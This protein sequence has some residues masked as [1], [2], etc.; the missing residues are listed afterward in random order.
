MPDG[1]VIEG[2]PEGFS[3]ADLLA[4]YQPK[5]APT[6]RQQTLASIP[7]R[8]LKGMKDPLDAGAQLLTHILPDS[9]VDAGNSLNNWLADKTGVVSRL[10]E[11]NLSSLVTGQK[12]GL[13]QALSDQEKE[14]QGARAATG[15]TGVDWARLGGNVASPVNLILAARVPQAATALGR[16]GT[17]AAT[18]G[19]F[20][21]L[22]PV[23]EGN[24]A[25]E[26]AKQIGL[27]AALGPVAQVGGEALARVANPQTRQAVLDL[28]HEGITPT[29]GQILGG[30][31][32]VFEDKLTSVPILGDAISSS[33]RTG[34]DELNTAAYRRSLEPIGGTMP[35]GVGR[36][37][38]A[39]IRNQISD[40]YDNLLP[41]VHFRADNQ[42]S[43]DI[44]QLR[45]MAA[46]LP[47]EQSARFERVLRN[48]VIGK[49]TPQ[50]T[51]DGQTLKGI[52]GD[53]GTLAS[54]LGR[55]QLFDNRQLGAALSEVQ[56]A[57]R[58]NLERANPQYAD[59]L[60]NAN[61]AWANFKRVQNASSKLG[62]EDG[63]FTPAQLQNAV[64][65]LDR[66][67]D[68]R[69]FSEGTALMQDLSDPAKSVLAS[70]Y[71][72]SGTPGRLMAGLA[73]GGGAAALS[74]TG[75]ALGAAGVLP[76]LPGG[77]QTAAWL[78]AGRQGPAAQ[79]VANAVRRIAPAASPALLG[80]FKP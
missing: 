5:S 41:N 20:G 74:P 48:Q 28:M 44:Q 34:L 13:D 54:G 37:A 2:V 29:P 1:T 47:P 14:Y 52:E 22:S 57:I 25:T 18:G 80:L 16:I 27:G 45:A 76:Y 51:M 59:E 71:P 39:D 4:K 15:N 12:G 67:K 62:A 32:Q 38:V 10:P 69:G 7:N 24:F 46:N 68:K 63:T 70:K 43:G 73:T 9:V 19:A 49:M 58:S 23:T 33:R 31:W 78:L 53:L 21:A 35:N 66:S 72:D 8:V 65:A 11:R 61:T 40:A 6:E 17:A 60:R 75:A 50:G 64:R 26:K 3:K 42:F 79:N 56:A 36:E 77:R 30:R 55:D